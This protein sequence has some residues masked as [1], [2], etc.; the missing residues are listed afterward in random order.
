ML[1]FNY[2]FNYLIRIL[3]FKTSLDI[4]I[5]NLFNIFNVL[6]LVML[7]V[8]LN[9]HIRSK[10]LNHRPFTSTRSNYQLSCQSQQVNS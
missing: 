10:L 5:K 8:R 7:S 2:L 9:G 4:Q 6:F 1:V 3:G